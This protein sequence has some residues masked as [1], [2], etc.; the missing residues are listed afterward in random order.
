MH[1]PGGAKVYFLGNWGDL[2]GWSGYLGSFSLC[3]DG[4]N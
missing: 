2:D 1:P 3:V 4:N